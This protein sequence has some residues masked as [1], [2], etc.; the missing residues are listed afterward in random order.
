MIKSNLNKLIKNYLIALGNNNNILT[1]DLLSG[2]VKSF[3]NNNSNAFLIGL[4]ADQSVKAE[5][6]WSLPY[7]LNDRIGTFDFE[8][9]VDSYT[10]DEL[11]QVIKT[12]PALHRYPNRMAMYIYNAMKDVLEKYEGSASNIWEGKSAEEIVSNLEEFKGISHKKASLGTLLLVRDMGLSVPDKENIDIAYDVHI[13]RI[14][15]RVGLVKDETEEKVL[16]A[17]RNLNPD[18]PGELTT[19]FWS[20]GRDFCHSNNPMCLLCPLEPVCEKNE[21][22]EKGKSK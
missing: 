19:A 18:F 5:L 8:N 13:K 12:K 1:G 11:E 21:Y 6:A 15:S 7:N 14:F 22:V 3:L 2:D 10:E 9:I 17:A 20:I 16:E 4:I